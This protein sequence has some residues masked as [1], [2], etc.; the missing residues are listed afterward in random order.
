V[1]SWPKIARHGGHCRRQDLEGRVRIEFPWRDGE[2]IAVGSSH[3]GPLLRVSRSNAAKIVHQATIPCL[4]LPPPRR[5]T[6]VS[7]AVVAPPSG[8]SE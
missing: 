5:L 6:K 2:I 1:A 7:Q 8:P 4:I 3:L